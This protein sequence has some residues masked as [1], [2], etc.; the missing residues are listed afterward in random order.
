MS[1]QN[2]GQSGQAIIDPFAI[3]DLVIAVFGRGD[4]K[5]NRLVEET[6]DRLLKEYELKPD[7]RPEIYERIVASGFKRP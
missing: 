7:L 2:S 6:R 1:E 4:A 5:I 3:Y